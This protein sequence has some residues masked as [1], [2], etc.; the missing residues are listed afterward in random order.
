MMKKTFTSGQR[1]KMEKNQEQKKLEKMRK[2]L[3]F[4]KFTPHCQ[5]VKIDDKKLEQMRYGKAE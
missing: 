4:L 2:I 1:K 3:F 5:R